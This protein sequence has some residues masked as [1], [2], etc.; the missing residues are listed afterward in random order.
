MRLNIKLN[1]YILDSLFL[2]LWFSMSILL[3]FFNEQGLIYLSTIT[4]SLTSAYFFWEL[5]K[6]KIWIF[7][8]VF[9]V[10]CFLFFIVRYISG[11]KAHITVLLIYCSSFVMAFYIFKNQIYIKIIYFYFVVCTFLL[12][13]VLMM[14]SDV[15][16]IFLGSRNV[17]S[18]LLVPMAA[19][20]LMVKR[21][22]VTPKD[23]LLYIVVFMCC[24]ISQGR[25]GILTSGLLLVVSY[26]LSFNSLGKG[27]L[28]FTT[29][30]F[31]AFSFLFFYFY[32][33]NSYFDYLRSSGVSDSYRK[34]MIDEYLSKLDVSSIIYGLDLSSL[35]YISSF[36]N[37]PH[38][39]F[40]F[41]HSTFG[42]IAIFYML[43]A[44]FSLVFLFTCK[45][46]SLFFCGVIVIIRLSTDSD[47]GFV[48]LPLS[49]MMIVVISKFFSYKFKLSH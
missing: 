35:P 49:F 7:L 33:S 41:M 15:N 26:F 46:Y 5:R 27:K 17:T 10:F 21:R 43:F 13:V 39:F 23:F 3:Y 37:N 45:E 12:W 47:Y 31:I 28:F 36:N 34:E 16:N 38:N 29:P 32:E 8:F 40:I 22:D 48:G 18:L 25:S 30:I 1:K 6:D 11:N 42:F 44:I 20:F 2:L 24:V 19:F 14:S 4:I 9:F